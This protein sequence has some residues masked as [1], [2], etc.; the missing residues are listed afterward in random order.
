MAVVKRAA[1]VQVRLRSAGVSLLEMMVALVILSVGAVVVFDWLAQTNAR[2]LVL[3]T[4][5]RHTLAKMK[6][7]TFLDTINPALAPRG[8]QLF[9]DFE[10]DWRVSASTPVRRMLD[11]ADAQTRFEMAVYALQVT[12]RWPSSETA[13]FETRLAGWRALTPAGVQGAPGQAV[14][15][16]GGLVSSFAELNTPPRLTGLRLP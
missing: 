3:Q 15:L 12:V 13:E 8:T 5:Q 11:P 9:D 10:V 7:A 6:A 4:Q 14:G 1:T 16:T 2:M